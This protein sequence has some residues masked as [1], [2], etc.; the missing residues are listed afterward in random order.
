MSR[1]LLT[2]AG[3][4]PADL[5][6]AV[7]NG[8][9]PRADYRVMAE[10][11]DAD[12]ID[13]REAASDSARWGDL[14]TR[15]VGVGPMLAWA[16][17]R[18]RRR[19]QTIVT[20]SEEVGIPLAVLFTFARRR[21]RHV[22]IVHRI[23]PPKKRWL[24]R[25]LRLRRGID[26]VVVYS[27]PQRD[28]A[29]ELGFAPERVH[30][31]PFMV[32]TAFWRPEAVERS[33]PATARPLVC[34]AGQELRDYPT[35]LAAVDGLDIDVVIGAAS[36]W[37]RRADTT[38]GATIPDNVTVDRFDLHALRQ[39]YADADVVVV[40]VVETDFQAGITTILEAMAMG[41][42]LIVTRTS[43]QGD[44]IVDGETGRY[45]A[46]GDVAGLRAILDSLA[47]DEDERARLGDNARRWAVEHA[48]I[49]VYAASLST[50]I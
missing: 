14:V 46:P 36:P 28:V 25:L 42:A 32:D 9:R 2:V 15:R 4:I 33:R 40:P 31:H 48:D 35:M 19:Y 20:D 12:V 47:D 1:T 10:R 45:V 26:D 44:T 23:S 24:M 16:C 37:S 11:F 3:E 21:P 38:A 27:S 50:I 8:R 34:S 43:G 49:E 18:R 30:L 7:A 5:D 6:E 29:I 41:R 22:M 39:L 17:F 13:A